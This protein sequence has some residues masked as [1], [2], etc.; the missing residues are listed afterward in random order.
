METP[1]IN[2][3]HANAKK[4]NETHE[5][6]CQNQTTTQSQPISS[7]FKRIAWAIAK[8]LILLL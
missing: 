6:R 8:L 3:Q 4:V 1:L 2:G 7:H 5:D